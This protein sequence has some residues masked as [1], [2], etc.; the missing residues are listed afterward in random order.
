MWITGRSSV[1]YHPNA[2]VKLSHTSLM[3]RMGRNERW[4]TLFSPKV[5]QVGTG[6]HGG[7]SFSV[8]TGKVGNDEEIGTAEK[9]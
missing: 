9:R 4:T 1:G 3:N 8:H 5:F 2:R 7:V 6:R